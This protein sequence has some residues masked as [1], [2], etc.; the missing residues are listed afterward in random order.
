MILGDGGEW[1]GFR[2]REVGMVGHKRAALFYTYD[3]MI[4]STWPAKMQ[5]ALDVMMC[6]FGRF[7][8][9][10]KGEKTVGM[11]CQMCR[12]ANIQS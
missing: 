4:A 9:W 11:V 3:V 1:V 10:N 8:L 7:V 6:L 5:E 12:T 2:S